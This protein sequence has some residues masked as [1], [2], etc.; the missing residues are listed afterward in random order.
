MARSR[1]P[2]ILAGLVGTVAL[3]GTPI[4][5]AATPE[6]GADAPAMH[7]TQ[8]SQSAPDL[9]ALIDK[10]ESQYNGKVLGIERE[11]HGK[12]GLYE[13]ELLDSNGHEQ[14]FHVNSAG[15]KVTSKPHHSKHGNRKHEN[16]E[17]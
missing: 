2:T 12:S 4:L 5:F 10:V 15:E 16:S 17:H 1:I 9:K 6:S 14:E 7:H 11:H 3:L 8:A 13:V